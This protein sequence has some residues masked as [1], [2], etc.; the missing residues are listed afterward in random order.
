MIRFDR[1]VI[2]VELINEMLKLFDIA[3]LGLIDEDGFPYVVPVNYGYEIVN[4]KLYIY[5]H[6][7]KR[8]HKVE[9]MK[10]NSKVCVEMSMFHD[11]PDCKYKGHY[12]DYRSVI[13]KGLVTLVDG[14]EDYETYK[15]GYNLLYTCNNREIIPLE[16][17]PKI[18][19]MYI[20]VIECDMKDVT[21][22]SEF[23]I[24][25]K[26]D[27]PFLDVYN[28]PQDDTPFDISDI[29]AKRKK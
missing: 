26:E 6:T 10:K 20:G 15:K 3:H 23:P 2:E 24:R 21:A 18:P 7:T 25:K 16:S 9:L 8:G 13:A 5:I 4:D 19:P 12:H 17:R 29:I 22:K 28:M 11:F 14:N 27:V 1:E